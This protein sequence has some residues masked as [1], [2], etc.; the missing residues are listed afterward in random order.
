M[1]NI[2]LGEDNERGVEATI[3]L[4]KSMGLKDPNCA[5]HRSLDKEFSFYVV[6][7]SLMHTVNYPTLLHIWYN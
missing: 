5:H 1:L 6:Y 2:Y 4:A 3:K 7:G